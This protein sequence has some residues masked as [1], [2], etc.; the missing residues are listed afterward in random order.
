MTEEEIGVKFTALGRDVVGEAR[1]KELG[2]VIM[3]L[4]Q[5]ESLDRLIRMMVE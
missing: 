3:K 1:C 5:Q 2:Q 4:D